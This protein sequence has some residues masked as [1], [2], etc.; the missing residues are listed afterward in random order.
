MNLPPAG[1]VYTATNAAYY[2]R[3][4]PRQVRHLAQIHGIG[5]R[6]GGQWLFTTA[7]LDRLYDRPKRGHHLK[8]GATK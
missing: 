7:E 2:L 5:T 8:I 3:L 6:V 1:R 4:S